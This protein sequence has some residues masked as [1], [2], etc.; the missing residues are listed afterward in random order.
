MST[1]TQP[2]QS[3]LDNMFYVGQQAHAARKFIHGIFGIW[4]DAGVNIAAGSLKTK[5]QEILLR[6]SRD[7]LVS[8]LDPD[9]SP[10]NP[11]VW[12]R[13]FE[14]HGESLVRGIQQMQKDL[15]ENHGM[16][17]ISNNANLK[18][19]V[20]LGITPCVVVYETPLFKLVRY[21]PT[22][23]TVYSTPLLIVPPKINKAY[24]LDLQPG[25]SFVEDMVNE[26]RVVFQIQWK[27]GTQAIA[28]TSFIDYLDSIA[29]AID[30]IGAPK[31]DTIGLCMGGL[32]LTM[33]NA[34]LAKTGRNV[35]N[36]QATIVTMLD[37]PD[38]GTGVAGAMITEDLLKNLERSIK[39]NGG[40]VN[41]QELAL[42]FTSLLP[43][44]LIHRARYK[45]WY[46]GEDLPEM[47]LMAWNSDSA[48]PVGKAYVEYLRHTFV[49]NALVNG[50]FV[51]HGVRIGIEDITIPFCAISGKTDHI[52]PSDTSLSS[53]AKTKG[54]VW[55]IRARGGHV[56]PIA[57][58]NNNPRN[59]YEILEDRYES[60]EAFER[61]TRMKRVKG[62]WNKEYAR[63]LREFSPE[64][65][66]V[67]SINF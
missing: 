30:H 5:N 33:V 39:A 28:N 44:S 15:R 9:F 53:A 55:T 35:V 14:T 11:E 23:T 20:N 66:P 52:V 61:D 65:I 67:S 63:F 7:H 27:E 38:G 62:N 60:R 47:P 31:I 21:Q 19:G 32:E 46:L 3:W 1:H 50:T 37:Y 24:I 42:L 34:Y 58:D 54:V 17:S 10:A 59:S 64:R 41:G 2:R 49:E 40:I 36:T 57:V 51:M 6:H 22:T 13:A 26:G 48:N 25:Q 18:E 56:A 4:V 12:Q 45:G 29:E 43:E 16:P 8:A